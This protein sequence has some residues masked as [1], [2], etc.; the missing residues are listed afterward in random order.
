MTC[1]PSCVF[2]LVLLAAVLPGCSN[3]AQSSNTAA[4]QTAVKAKVA[5]FIDTDDCSTLTRQ[6]IESNYEGEAD[7]M[8]ACKS[9]P[10]HGMGKGDYKIKSAS[11]SGDK[12]TVVAIP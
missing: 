11:V 2:S 5:Q 4:D 3:S 9:D 10:F 12:A 7:P 8:Q 6:L 1:K